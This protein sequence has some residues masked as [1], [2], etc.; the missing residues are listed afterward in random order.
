MMEEWKRSMIVRLMKIML[1]DHRDH[2]RRRD[3][4]FALMQHSLS[5]D[6]VSNVRKERLEML[7]D[8]HKEYDELDDELRYRMYSSIMGNNHIYRSSILEPDVMKE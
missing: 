4:Q 3:E 6:I 1:D 8:A 2:L 5:N 7:I